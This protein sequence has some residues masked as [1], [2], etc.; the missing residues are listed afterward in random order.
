MKEA[1]EQKCGMALSQLEKS[2]LEK[3]H[4][5]SDLLVMVDRQKA[6][7]DA[8]KEKFEVLNQDLSNREDEIGELKSFLDENSVQEKFKEMNAK[9][10]Q[11]KLDFDQ[12]SGEKEG[13][14]D[15]V[16][17]Q[18]DEIHQIE[19]KFREIEEKLSL[20]EANEQEFGVAMTALNDKISNYEQEIQS[21]KSANDNREDFVMDLKE[22]LT[23][24]STELSSKNETIQDQ[25]EQLEE[26][27]QMI[28]KKSQIIQ[29]LENEMT[30][31]K[32]KD[33]LENKWHL[34]IKKAH[35]DEI[36]TLKR[37]VY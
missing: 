26:Q 37:Y 13:L 5:M 21:L 35:L 27:N 17:K 23:S 30:N 34:E 7:N 20:K 32:E 11:S 25:S 18:K 1:N 12:V 3:T 24:F 6:E 8:F 33:I 28:L 15:Q 2:L 14:A 4:E 31:V 16:Q 36:E 9:L 22:K 10:E 19:E 29:N